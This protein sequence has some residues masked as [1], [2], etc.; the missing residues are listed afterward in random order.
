MSLNYFSKANARMSAVSPTSI[1]MLV[2]ALQTPK[3]GPFPAK[4]GGLVVEKL[5]QPRGAGQTGSWWENHRST[6]FLGTFPRWVV[7]PSAIGP[8]CCSPGC[9]C[10]CPGPC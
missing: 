1:L 6:L 4:A 5:T 10:P 2:I 7:A 3:Q 9:P 8:Q